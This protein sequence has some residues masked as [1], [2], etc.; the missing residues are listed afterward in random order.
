MST[1][2]AHLHVWR[3]AEGETPGIDT[4]VPP[5]EDV[6]I[7]RAAAELATH[8]VARAVL[9]QPV[10]RGEDN[11]YVAACARAEPERFAAVCVVDPRIAGCEG[12]LERW[13]AQRCRGLRLR[14]RLPDEAA[15]FGSPAA[16]PL[17]RA[18]ERLGVVVSLLANCEHAATVD[19]LAARHPGVS[20]VIDH[21]GHPDP[22][23]GVG[24]AG[25][26]QLLALARHPRVFIKISGFYHFSREP[27][28]YADCHDLVRAC[29]DAFGPERL[30]WG[31][32]YPHVLRACGYEA[33][34]QLLDI[35][36]PS[37]SSPER[38]LVMSANAA[39]LY[40]AGA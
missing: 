25:F 32:D 7:Q 5:Q 20:I 1:I 26:R 11:S 19:V 34:L 16:D 9:V 13:V 39:R 28:P 10:F 35:A 37:W 18:T 4:I 12:R 6:T 8:G 22:A 31:S 23:K 21:L 17:W 3:A 2:D 30:V 36:L 29:Y 24:D 40:W 33:A 15:I 38:D 14:P 27:F